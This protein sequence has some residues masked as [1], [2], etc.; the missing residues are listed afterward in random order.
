[1]WKFSLWC[2]R[3]RI[4][5]C[6]SCGTGCNCSAVSTLGPG[7]SICHRY[8]QKN[9]HLNVKSKITENNIEK[10]LHDLIVGKNLWWQKALSI[11]NWVDYIKIKNFYSWKNAIKKVKREEKWE[12]IFANHISNK[13]LLNK[14]LL[15]HN[16][17]TTHSFNGQRI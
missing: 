17:K 4:Q 12:I 8:S 9:K 14:E 11:M 2:S 3:L 13:R 6:H 15:Q 5:C 16:N 10:Y 1:M 7:T